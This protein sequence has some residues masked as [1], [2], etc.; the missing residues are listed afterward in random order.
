LHTPY[1]LCKEVRGEYIR[2]L[3]EVLI[4]SFLELNVK[5]ISETNQKHFD[6]RLKFLRY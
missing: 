5:T 4:V 3:R 1:L 6:T 2:S